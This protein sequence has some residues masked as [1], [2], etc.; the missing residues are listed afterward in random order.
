VTRAR[1]VCAGVWDFVVGDDWVAAVGVVVAIG[2]T[3][4]LARVGVAAW[5][6]MPVAVVSVL[7]ASLRRA[8]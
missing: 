1:S 7:G 8:P 3:A 2:V 4:G 6:V 5:W